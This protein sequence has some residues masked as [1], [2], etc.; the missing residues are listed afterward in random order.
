[1]RRKCVPGAKAAPLI[2]SNPSIDFFSFSVFREPK[3]TTNH[4]G[5]RLEIEARNLLIFE[6]IWG[7]LG[8]H[9]GSIF[10]ARRGNFPE[11][12]GSVFWTPPG[13][14][15]DGQSGAPGVPDTDRGSK[16]ESNFGGLG[17]CGG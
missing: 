13:A 12:F 10:G 7:S 16:D 6:V 15:P 17:R 14:T 4:V 8:E 1:M 3:N 11:F 5:K 9:F 2:F